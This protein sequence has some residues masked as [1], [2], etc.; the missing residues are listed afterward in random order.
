MNTVQYFEYT[1]GLLVSLL[2]LLYQLSD[3]LYVFKQVLRT[4]MRT[5]RFVEFP[6]LDPKKV[7]KVMFTYLLHAYFVDRAA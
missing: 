7:F 2:T 5:K 3:Y 1:S 4:E 6:L